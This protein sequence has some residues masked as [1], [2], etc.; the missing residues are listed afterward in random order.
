MADDS[1][2]LGRRPKRKK[3]S[4][5]PPAEP[6]METM[7][8][9]LNEQA[10][11]ELEMDPVVQF[12]PGL[13]WVRRAAWMPHCQL[14][15]KPLIDPKTGEIVKLSRQELLMVAIFSAAIN[16]AHPKQFE[17][18]NL[19]ARYLWGVVPENLQVTG[20]N[21][22]PVKLQEVP[23]DPAEIATRIAAT[24]SVLQDIA[25]GHE[26]KKFIPVEVR[27]APQVPVPT[28]TAEVTRVAAPVPPTPQQPVPPRPPATGMVRIR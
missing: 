1:T 6:S 24:L 21:G 9:E 23:D 28:V 18:A 10:I 25:G 3:A 12:R 27:E 22:G 19:A 2:G 4:K 15:G 5:K 16:P 7:L 20:A 17:F 13:R 14:N 8:S 11:H 26:R